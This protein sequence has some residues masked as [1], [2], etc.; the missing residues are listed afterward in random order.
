MLSG[1]PRGQL[2]AVEGGVAKI[3]ASI[4]QRKQRN[5]ERFQPWSGHILSI[6]PVWS[7]HTKM[8]TTILNWK[9]FKSE[10]LDG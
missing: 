5:Q 10:Q 3:S 1:G 2:Q 7:P 8:N 4:T 6:Q 9:M